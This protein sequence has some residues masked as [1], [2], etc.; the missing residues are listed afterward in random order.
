MTDKQQN[1]TTFLALAVLACVLG[2]VCTIGILTFGKTDEIIQGQ[3]EVNEY[4]VSSKVPGRILEFRVHEG[5]FVKAGDTLAIIEAPEVEAKKAQAEAVKTAAEAQNTKAEKGARKEQIQAAY[6]MWQKAKTGREITE[7]SYNRISNLYKEGVVSEQ[8]YDE[9]KAQ[10]D[11]AISTENAA[12]AQ[13]TLAVKGAQEEDK[14]MAAAQVKQAEGVVAEVNS[15]INET[16]LTAYAD[17][18]VTD[19]YP[20]I[21]ELVGTGAPIMS[22]AIMNDV[23]ATFNVREDYLKKMEIG[24]EFDAYIPALETTAKMKVNYMKD[25]GDFAAW[26][27]TKQTGQYDLKTFEVRAVPMEEINGLRPGMTVLYN[28]NK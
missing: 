5:Q 20:H 3:A 6:E 9:V 2:V 25:M 23:W 12:K 17:G 19:I 15:Y 28:I 22:V 21:G 16:I 27:A 18:E 4:R 24:T 10:Y 13:Y 11:A 1:I 8:K 26:K 7:K 14:E